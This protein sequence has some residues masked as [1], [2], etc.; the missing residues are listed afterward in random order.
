MLGLVEEHLLL[1]AK[2][3]LPREKVVSQLP[4][5]YSHLPFPLA[6]V[7]ELADHGRFLRLA[8]TATF[9]RGALEKHD[10]ERAYVN[11]LTVQGPLL[12]ETVF[13]HLDSEFRATFDSSL[14]YGFEN[15]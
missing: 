11:L 7:L 12:S 1:A 15:H 6:L 4:R 9:L 3:G 8:T 5:T 14:K 13:L 10:L 2:H